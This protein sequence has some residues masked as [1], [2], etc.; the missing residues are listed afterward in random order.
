VDHITA[1]RLA[2]IGPIC[3]ILLRQLHFWSMILCPLTTASTLSIRPKVPPVKNPTLQLSGQPCKV[4]RS[5]LQSR[6]VNFG[7]GR[8]QGAMLQV[9]NS[10]ETHPFQTSCGRR[11]ALQSPQFTFL[12][13]CQISAPDL[14]TTR[15]WPF[16]AYS[17]HPYTHELLFP[18]MSLTVHFLHVE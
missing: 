1:R 6:Q 16:L 4:D 2:A 12:L 14:P 8:P 17:F 15:S 10:F 5:T 7:K 3:G 11:L 13:S 9:P 18:K